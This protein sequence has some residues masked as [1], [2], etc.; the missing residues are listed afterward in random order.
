MYRFAT[1]SIES[2]KDLKTTADI[3][4]EILSN[5]KFHKDQEHTF[6]EI[7][8]YLA[9]DDTFKYALLGHANEDSGKSAKKEFHLTMYPKERYADGENLDLSEELAQ[10]LNGDG[11]LRCWT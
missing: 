8:A 7:P 3:V 1:V 10:K 9:T 6:D 2:F 11:R 4:G 5:V